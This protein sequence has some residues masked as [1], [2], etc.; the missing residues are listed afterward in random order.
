MARKQAPFR[1]VLGNLLSKFLEDK[2]ACGYRYE[3]EEYILRELD[4]FLVARKLRRRELSRVLVEEWTAAKT[5]ERPRTQR[6]RLTVVRQLASFLCRQGYSAYVP[7]LNPRRGTR[8]EFT[9]RIFSR[10]EIAR[11]LQAADDLPA[12]PWSPLYHLVIPEIF[13]VLY[14]CG[15]RQGEVLR[16]TVGDVDL[17]D[18]VLRI[19][20][21]KFRKDRLVPMAPGLTHRLRRYAE[22]LGVRDPGQ[23]FFPSPRGGVYSRRGLY[24]TFRKLLRAAG[25]PHHGRGRGPRLHEIRH[26]FAVHRLERWYAEGADLNAKLPLLSSYMGHRSMDGT[27][28][29]LQLTQSLFSDVA[30]RLEAVCGHVI[31]TRGTES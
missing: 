24:S 29:Y 21:G 3:R 16:L 22:V 30:A 27:Q 17:N 19:R 5:H 9:A 6:M 8:R 23:P 18:G 31:P 13:R 25:I 4:R 15:L 1:S 7:P 12:R 10:Q 2:R 11:I 20:E 28:V 26:S 14:G